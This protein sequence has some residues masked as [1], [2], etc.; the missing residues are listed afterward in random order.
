[1]APP[2]NVI[3]AV[4]VEKSGSESRGRFKC[5]V[6][7][8]EESEY[9]DWRMKVEGWIYLTR[10]NEE[11]QGL[12][13][14]QGL[15]GKALSLVKGLKWDVLIGKDGGK[16]VLKKLDEFYRKEQTW[17][18]CC[19]IAQFAEMKRKRDESVKEFILRYEYCLD[20]CE[21][22]GVPMLVGE[23]KGIFLLQKA[24]VTE[25]QMKM[26]TSACGE[27]K[28]EYDRVRRIMRRIFE[29]K[30]TG[31]K[32][33]EGWYGRDRRDES[34]RGGYRGG[35]TYQRR[36]WKNP[37]NKFGVI[38]KCVICASEEHW[39]RQCPKNVANRSRGGEN[40]RRRNEDRN[41]DSN[42]ETQKVYMAETNDEKYWDDVEAILDSGCKSSVI[43][44]M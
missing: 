18:R 42:D 41:N 1:M 2:E 10:N 8:G 33:D 17:D 32:S 25:E 5:P 31:E 44:E 7:K 22:I 43:G 40:S 35:Q 28:L 37:V 20:E 6:F 27:E 36:E 38:S 34:R 4:K 9:E 16:E 29:D 39:A 24:N 19:K 12:V 30:D 3:E 11:A 23:A 13:I 15:E 21:K 26:V 14:M